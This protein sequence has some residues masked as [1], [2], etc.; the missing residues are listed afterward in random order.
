MTS[1]PKRQKVGEQSYR[2]VA[3]EAYNSENDQ[4]D[5]LFE[6]HG[7][8][9]TLPF[10]DVPTQP[11]EHTSGTVAT[12]P[13][14][15]PKPSLY[16][17]TFELLSSTPS[18]L[19]SSSVVQVEASSPSQHH[20][21]VT[22]RSKPIP[23][24]RGAL[25]GFA[26]AMA[27]PGTAY[28][29]P[30]Q[31]PPERPKGVDLSDDSSVLHSDSSDNEGT[32]K[33]DIKPSLLSK[34]SRPNHLP[35]ATRIEESPKDNTKKFKSLASQF[36]YNQ[37]P[38]APVPDM[39]SAY[40]A[41]PRH[42]ARPIPKQTGPARARPVQDKSI[43]DIPDDGIRHKI[44]NM[45][46]ILPNQTVASCEHALAR[47]RGNMND[48]M[49]LLAD[50]EE[51]I[52]LTVDELAAPGLKTAA[53]PKPAAKRHVQAPTRSIQDK[54]SSTQ[55]APR[56]TQVSNLV[57]SSPPSS[58]PKPQPRR[59]LV[60]GRK[61]RSSPTVA[62]SPPPLPLPQQQSTKRQIAVAS[63]ES[64]SGLGTDVV[65]TSDHTE[66]ESRLLN[67]INTCSAKELAD[68]SN[69][70]LEVAN[71]IVSK[72]PFV[73]LDKVRHVSSHDA[74]TK[75]GKRST[76]K[77]IGDKIVD[78]CL[79]MWTG[80]EAVDELVL[81]C[82]S[83]GQS[84]A[85]E[86]QKWGFDVFGASKDGELQLTALDAA[87][88]SGIGT[89]SSSV[90]DDDS[91]SKT[92]G[93]SK[94]GFIRQPAIMSE[95]LQLKDYQVAGL[96]W[97]ALLYRKGLSCILADD[98][99][100]G[101]T[102][103]VIAFLSHLFETGEHGCHLIVVPGST[104]EN[105]LREFQRFSPALNVEPYYGL[106]NE[107]AE[108]RVKIEDNIRN[109][110]V[111]ITTYDLAAQAKDASF[112]RHQKPTVCVYDEGHALR[113]STSKRYKALMR[114]PAKFRLLLT[115][116]PLQNNLQE[117]V[118]LLNFL[119]PN[120]FAGRE[121]DLASIFKVCVLVLLEKAHQARLLCF[122]QDLVSGCL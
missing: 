104:L 46:K 3:S 29:A 62:S 28:R 84:V 36:T 27:P 90:S 106:Q 103:Q 20:E 96:N 109:I 42:T 57:L 22:Q 45:M 115:G 13:L 74:F 56:P 30:V 98:M 102:C 52:D 15:K 35:P 66:L 8:A 67:F 91:A 50:S 71:L 38:R 79:E 105:W 51:P 94:N 19:P 121:E 58:V 114:I 60:Q 17:D 6:E 40:G 11:L 76:K 18:A 110:N 54:Y 107:R 37:P 68:I 34:S 97:L 14:S 31:A 43:D 82:E 26:S 108:Q 75:T 119:M 10:Q 2:N 93:M 7:R 59:R 16:S 24:A 25:N 63:D 61:G 32:S 33:A 99:G 78:V 55:T 116:T 70:T 83:L 9:S 122:L 88:D 72:R 23:M 118:S 5:V 111:I 100:L 47:R 77:A 12:V 65:E 80:Y 92:L 21:Q 85:K 87:Q 113:N 101:K 48:A 89:P 120:V 49:E 81:T 1:T 39:A 86:M 53:L 41:H 44:A 95:D 73:D 4:G 112:L 69:Q 117:L 64:D